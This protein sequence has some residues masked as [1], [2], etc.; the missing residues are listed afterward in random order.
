MGKRH[1]MTLNVG[2]LFQW[3]KGELMRKEDQSWLKTDV[4]KQLA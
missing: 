2:K 3:N 4:W 1:E